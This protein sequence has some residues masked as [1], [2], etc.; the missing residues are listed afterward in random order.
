MIGAATIL[1]CRVVRLPDRRL[2]LVGAFGLFAIAAYLIESW[3][4][5]GL[6]QYR[7]AFFIGC[8]LGTVEAARRIG[9]TRL[10]RPG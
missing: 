6:S 10:T 3:Y 4:D 5:Q 7:T 8:V 2:A 1:A 9:A